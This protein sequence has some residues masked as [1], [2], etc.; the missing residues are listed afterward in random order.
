MYCNFWNF[1]IDKTAKSKVT[2]MKWAF[3]FGSTLN[4]QCAADSKVLPLVKHTCFAG[5]LF[6]SGFTSSFNAH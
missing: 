4:N 1:L 6:R 2:N 3:L 5:K